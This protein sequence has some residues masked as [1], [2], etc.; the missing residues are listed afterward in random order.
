MD[1]DGAAKQPVFETRFLKHLE[2]R[3]SS[4]VKGP[5]PESADRPTRGCYQRTLAVISGLVFKPPRVVPQLGSVAYHASSF[6]AAMHMTIDK[7]IRAQRT[8]KRK[9]PSVAPRLPPITTATAR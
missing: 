8:G 9:L 3:E 5:A 4:R 7:R 1:A 6:A 2:H